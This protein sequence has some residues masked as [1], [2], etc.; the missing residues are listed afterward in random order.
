MQERRQHGIRPSQEP[1][2]KR[3]W[4]TFFPERASL[5][6][7]TEESKL[8]QISNSLPKGVKRK[9]QKSEGI[10]LEKGKEIV[11]F[12]WGQRERRPHFWVWGE[13]KWRRRFRLN[14]K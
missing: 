4:L 7:T 9:R 3:K 5:D 11:D 6:W 14:P 2:G 1:R 8:T 10:P 13:E 12:L